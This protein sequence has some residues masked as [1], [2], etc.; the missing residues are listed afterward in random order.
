M[1][2][3]T[4]VVYRPIVTRLLSATLARKLTVNAVSFQGNFVWGRRLFEFMASAR[5]SPGVARTVMG[6]RFASPAGVGPHV[7]LDGSGLRMWR[8]LG[9]GFTVVG[10]V[11]SEQRPKG[12]SSTRMMHSLCGILTS[13]AD[14]AYVDDV[15]PQLEDGLSRN[16]PVFVSATGPDV[17]AVLAKLG[18]RADAYIVPN[19]DSREILA[20]WATVTDRP[21]LVR[22]PVDLSPDEALRLGEHALAAGCA[23][24][25]L[26]GARTH[27]LP[28]GIEHGPF[29][30]ERAAALTRLLRSHFGKNLAVVAGPGIMTPDDARAAL[31]NG[32]DLLALFEGLIF[33]GPGLPRRI[34]TAIRASRTPQSVV[35]PAPPPADVSRG[36][37]RPAL[38]GLGIVAG[39]LT[40]VG[41]AGLLSSLTAPRRWLASEL[42]AANISA[43]AVE[44]ADGPLAAF[45]VHNRV[46]LAGAMV[47]LGLLWAWL[48][49]SPLR[50]GKPWAWWTL[51]LSGSAATAGLLSAHLATLPQRT[52]KTAAIVAASILFFVSLILCFRSLPKEQRGIG[53]LAKPGATAWLWSPAGRGRALLALSGLGLVVGGLLITT[54]GHSAVLVPQDVKYLGVRA[55]DLS[56]VSD[57]LSAFIAADRLAFGAMLLAAGIAVLPT[58]W[59]GLR[60]GARSLAVAVGAALAA[61]LVPAIGIHPVIGYNDFGHLAPFIAI[62]LYALAGLA[63]LWRPLS[64]A[65]RPDRFPDLWVDPDAAPTYRMTPTPRD[66]LMN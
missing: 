41:L 9:A 36:P 18:S 31:K 63:L 19:A 55:E 37:H 40:L 62:G 22:L 8:H 10:P 56:L 48:A 54:V 53:T 50:E 21:V 49:L 25:V 64:A 6:L 60:P 20:D 3:Y 46:N 4:Y 61:A 5:P 47:C 17:T 34:N 66:A 45:I 58:V 51:L 1:P 65:A 12:A 38:A 16:G 52:D 2:D 42:G 28:G 24:L 26:S 59:C 14:A 7:D 35:L 39:L 15:I 57:Q 44:K 30:R 33:A 43:A 27:L 11:S 32:A 23:G 13:V 29:L